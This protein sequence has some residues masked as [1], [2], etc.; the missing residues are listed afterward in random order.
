MKSYWDALND[1][2]KQLLAGS[3]NTST[4]YLR[5]VFNGYRKVGASRA[6]EIE[7]ATTRFVTRHDLRPDIFDKL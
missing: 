2:Q 4:D 6:K 5:Q 1:E 3:L 7:Y